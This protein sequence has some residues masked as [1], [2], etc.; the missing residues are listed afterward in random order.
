[1]RPAFGGRIRTMRNIRIVLWAVVVVL[2]G[3]VR[4]VDARNDEDP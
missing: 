4:L 3:V 1:M 2:V